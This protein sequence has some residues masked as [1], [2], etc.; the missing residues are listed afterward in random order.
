[1]M[2]GDD[3]TAQSS[4]ERQS[5]MPFGSRIE[6]A[7]C[8]FPVS[9]CVAAALAAAA[10][11]EPVVSHITGIAFKCPFLGIYCGFFPVVPLCAI[12]ILLR[13]EIGEYLQIFVQ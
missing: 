7:A 4:D 2:M 1:M 13:S 12:C 8:S 11:Q 9:R 6:T 10:A 3:A 5:W